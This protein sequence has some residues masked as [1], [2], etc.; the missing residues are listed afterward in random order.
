[1][2]LT[3]AKLQH[4]LEVNEGNQAPNTAAQCISKR[5]KR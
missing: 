3:E 4:Q 1:M 5:A 2:P